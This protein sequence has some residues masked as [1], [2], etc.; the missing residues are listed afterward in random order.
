MEHFP[1][2]LT[3]RLDWSEMDFFGHINNVSY[4]KYIQ[5]SRVN[6]WELTGASASFRDT[7]I[8]PILHS[9]GCRFIA[10]LHY[11]GS[12]TVECRVEH[13][14][15]TSFGIHHRI[16]NEQGIVCAEAHDVIVNYDFRNNQKTPITDNFRQSVA[17]IEKGNEPQ[18]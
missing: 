9:T 5:A 17:A 13:M 16:L 2:K 7:G 3:L 14:G 6:Y 15:T 1:V 18:N 12:I 10:P 11:P 8:G 4:F